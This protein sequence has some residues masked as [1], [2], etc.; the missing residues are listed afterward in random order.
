MYP[1]T[2]R[3]SQSDLCTVIVNWLRP[4]LY[5]ETALVRFS[6][7]FYRDSITTTY[8][9]CTAIAP[10]H[11]KNCAMTAKNAPYLSCHRDNFLPKVPGPVA[12][13]LRQ[14]TQPPFIA[15]LLCLSLD[16]LRDNLF[17]STY[18]S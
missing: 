17:L 10:A 16:K 6:N 1:D 5:R 13:W 7:F 2:H 18:R 9:N 11:N 15:W 3:R 14:V 4:Y 8:K 12:G